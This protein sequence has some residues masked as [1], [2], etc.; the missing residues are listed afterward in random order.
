[1][2][3]NLGNYYATS[4]G[5]QGESASY[6]YDPEHAIQKGRWVGG[7]EGAP[8]WVPDST[9]ATTAIDEAG[10]S[11]AIEARMARQD[12][13]A[14]AAQAAASSDPAYG[15]LMRNFSEA[16]PEFQKFGEAAP[17]M[18]KFGEA[19]WKNDFVAQ[20]GIQFGLDEGRKGIERQQSASG[21]MFSGATQK[22]LARFAV[23]YG[24]KNT[25]GAYDRFTSGQNRDYGQYVD[26]YNRFNNDQSQNYGRYVD[27]YNRFNNDQGNTFNRLST[28]AGSG[29]VATNQVGAAGQNYANRVSNTAEGMGNAT[30]AAGI[31]GSNAISGGLRGAYDNYQDNRLI[32]RMRGGSGIKYSGT[33]YNPYAPNY[34]N[35]FDRM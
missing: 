8:V 35:S 1:M 26:K 28:I 4:E 13:E 31:A 25:A 15:S 14:Q 23:D 34:E 29:Q 18:R 33:S 24:T 32:D 30:A 16:A 11:A 7:G 27:K 3:D 12:Q 21:S 10:L 20:N 19:D 22:A 6:Y 5:G 2:Y 9:T 17:E